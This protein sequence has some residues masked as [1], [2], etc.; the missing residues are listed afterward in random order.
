MIQ[1]EP[2]FLHTGQTVKTSLTPHVHAVTVATFDLN[3]T[4]YVKFLDLQNTEYY[5]VLVSAATQ[6]VTLLQNIVGGEFTL[7]KGLTVSF[8]PQ[9]PQQFTIFLNGMILD[10]KE[11]YPMRGK[12]LGTFTRT[13]ALLKNMKVSRELEAS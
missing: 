4:T 10:S 6:K 2:L 12:S 3:N 8:S 7:V 11:E 1:R 9:G 5:R 13:T